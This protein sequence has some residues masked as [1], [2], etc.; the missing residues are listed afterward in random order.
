MLTGFIHIFTLH[1]FLFRWKSVTCLAVNLIT[2][3]SKTSAFF[4]HSFQKKD[5]SPALRYT[6]NRVHPTSALFQRFFSEEDQW[7][8]VILLTALTSHPHFSS[9]LFIPPFQEKI[10][11]LDVIC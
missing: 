4:I 10:S 8:P 2:E 11:G 7:P 6:G 5:Q 1:P 9:S 3:F